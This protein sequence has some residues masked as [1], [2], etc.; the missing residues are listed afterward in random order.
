MEGHKI[1]NSYV[2]FIEIIELFLIEKGH[3][4][5]SIR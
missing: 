2:L 4:R 3:K 5:T 1:P